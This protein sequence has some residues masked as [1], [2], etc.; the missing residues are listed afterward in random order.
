M[1]IIGAGLAGLAAAVRLAGAGRA[2][3]VHEAT[4]LPVAA[5][6]P[7]TTT[8][9][10]MTDRQ[11][12]APPD[13]GQI[14]PRLAYAE[15]DRLRGRPAAARPRPNS[16]LSISRA[17]RAG[18]CAS[19]TA[20]CPWW[21]FDKERRVPETRRRRLS[22]AGAARSRPGR[23]SRSATS[24]IA[25]VRLYE[26]LL[27]PLLLAALNIEPRQGS[28][29]LAAA[30]IRETLAQGGK[31]CRP[32]LARDGFGKVFV[33]PALRLSAAHGVSIVLQDELVA[34]HFSGGRVARL[35]FA[36]R[37]ETS[38][39]DDAVILA[40]PPYAAKKLLPDLPV[41]TLFRGIVNAHFRVDP[42]AG[43][44]PMLGVI[45]GTV[46][47]IFSL[48]GRMSVTISSA[49]RLFQMP[50]EELA[51]TIWQRRRQL[52]GL[53]DALPPWQLVRERRATFAATPEQNALRPPA[54]DGVALISCWPATGPRPACRRRS[55]GAIR[56]GNRAADLASAKPCG[57]PHE[58][59]PLPIRRAAPE[60][61]LEP[62]DRRSKPRRAPCSL[63]SAATATGCS[64]S[65]PTATIPA[66][67]V[68]LRHYRGEPVDA[69][70]EA[71]DRRLSAPH[72]GRA[73][74]LAAV[75]RRRLRHERQ[76]ES[77]FRAEDDRRLRPMRRTCAAR[78]RRCLRAA[79]RS[80]ATCSPASCWRSTAF[81]AGTACR[82]CRS[83]S[84]CCRAG[85][86]FHLTKI[87][88]WA[89][90]GAR[91]A[92]GAAWRSSRGRKIRAAS[93]IDELFVE[94]AG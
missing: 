93:T 54:R 43:M 91:A 32:L 88:Y 4:L 18:R 15:T 66:E 51:Q 62:S 92:P 8:Q 81:C 9:T 20:V 77:L 53:P 11:R 84:C 22:A 64:S 79:A 63:C 70:L 27:E 2:I 36:D 46:Q 83:R 13:V 56:S 33:E 24:P 3:A 35:E 19:T 75:P 30:L 25:A 57:L 86:P 59:S 45:N 37:S 67:Y 14:M 21:V 42:P 61:E 38:A 23:T 47:W 40:V 1:H 29:K 28:A 17:R 39:T 76:R 74:R 55:R 58:R 94:T 65:K 34:L 49:D 72:P 10:G 52:S 16:R 44:P 90:H 5:A 71:Q 6:A 48:P 31:A 69:E 89:P 87:S 82:K 7:I 60:R 41:P 78:A 68:L 80:T 85:F 50:R 26:R 12:H 73:R